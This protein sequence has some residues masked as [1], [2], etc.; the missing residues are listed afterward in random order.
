MG[1]LGRDKKE[2]C[3]VS[4]WPSS[5]KQNRTVGN[6]AQRCCS[7]KK[8]ADKSGLVRRTDEVKDNIVKDERV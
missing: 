3:V 4:L 8:Q 7:E 2:Q 6:K 1:I 5:W